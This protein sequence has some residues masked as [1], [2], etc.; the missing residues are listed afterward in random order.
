MCVRERGRKTVSY[1]IQI[2][3]TSGQPDQST[4]NVHKCSQSLGENKL[5]D[6]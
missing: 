3:K 4:L 5:K 6:Q 1:S 2:W